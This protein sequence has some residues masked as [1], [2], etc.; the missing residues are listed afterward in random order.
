M[1]DSSEESYVEPQVVEAVKVLQGKG[2]R[3][4][5]LAGSAGSPEEGKQAIV[6]EYPK[7]QPGKNFFEA[8]VLERLRSLGVREYSGGQHVGT[9]GFEFNFDPKDAPSLARK[10][11]EIAEVLPEVGP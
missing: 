10:W 5:S 9:I 8:G 6:F 2:Y 11:M 7:A 4:G 3:V 1:L